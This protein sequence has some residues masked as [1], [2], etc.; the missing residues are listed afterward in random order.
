VQ[1]TL[2]KLAA[3]PKLYPVDGVVADLYLCATAGGA[4]QHRDEVE[5][6]ADGVVGDRYATESG[7]WSS[8]PAS[9][10]A[11]TLVEEE[12]ID[13]VRRDY[14]IDLAPGATRRNVVTRGV[15]LNHL[16]GRTFRVGEVEV[17]G[18]RLAE[19]CAHLEALTAKGVRRALVHRGGLRGEVVSGGTVRVGD[20][21]R[22]LETSENEQGEPAGRRSAPGAPRR[23]RSA[24]APP[25]AHP[26]SHHPKRDIS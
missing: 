6:H 4:M 7:S 10:R 15:A 14:D 22:T 1:K 19:P 9:G 3:A 26:I 16:V 12:A 17:V 11:L 25:G 18:V 13:A 20:P 21:I 24:P 2:T 23:R 5:V 8:K